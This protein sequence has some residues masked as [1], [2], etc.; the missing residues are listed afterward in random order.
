MRIAFIGPARGTSLHRARALERLGHTV[1][2]I[3]PWQWLSQ[4]KWVGRW[5]HRTGGVGVGLYIDRRLFAAVT[6][7]QPELIFVNQG[8]FLGPN[9]LRRL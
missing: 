9:Q 3:D 6:A 8:E 4:S 1:T 2:I 7:A 5:L